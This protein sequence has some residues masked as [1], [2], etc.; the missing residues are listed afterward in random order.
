M[1]LFG[2]ILIVKEGDDD[3]DAKKDGEGGGEG[4]IGV[5]EGLLLGISIVF[6]GSLSFSS[7]NS[8]ERSRTASALTI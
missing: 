2:D 5:S 4:G 3:G 8:S 7:C 6:S 1:L